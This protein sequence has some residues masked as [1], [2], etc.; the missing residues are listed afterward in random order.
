MHQL[1]VDERFVETAQAR[2]SA[3]REMALSAEQLFATLQHGPAWSQW[4]PVIREVVWTSPQPFTKG[5]T[6][7]VSLL[8]GI[9]LEE[10]FWAW[11]PNRRMGFSVTASTNPMLSA[12]AELYEITP[13][14]V[15]RCSLRWTLAMS[16]RGMLGKIEP[17]MKPSLP[18]AQERLLKT[19]ERV[20]RKHN[21]LS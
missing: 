17:Y 14:G 4:V 1:N 15:D 5:T 11:E 20:A 21:G 13:L 16:L 6:R 18:R 19:L 9:K 2:G 7:T 10:V 3:E 12:L 8:G